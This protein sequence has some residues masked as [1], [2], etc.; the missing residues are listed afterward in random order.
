LD[1]KKNN[2]E[3]KYKMK[4]AAVKFNNKSGKQQSKREKSETKM[5]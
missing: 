1:K 5:K 4:A 3:V 2:D